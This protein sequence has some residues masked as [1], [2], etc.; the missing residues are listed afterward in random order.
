VVKNSGDN[1]KR[2]LIEHPLDAEWT[3]V[4][5]EN[6]AE[7]TRDRYR[8]ALE[9]RPGEPAKLEVREQQPISERFAVN[10]LNDDAIGVYLD[11]KGVAAE[12]KAALAEVQKRKGEL[13]A[14]SQQRDR[15]QQR[16]TAITQEQTRIRDNMTRLDRNGDLYNRYVKK[17]S[18]QE[19]EV[20]AL[21]KQS[22]KLLDEIQRGREGLSKYVAGLDLE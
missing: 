10:D 5:P 18:E 19:N 3:L 15:L 22:E 14:L 11:A 17:F 9:A 20:E 7:K 2:L 8:F 21:A 6:A 13:A 4:A 12:V 16:L 1:P